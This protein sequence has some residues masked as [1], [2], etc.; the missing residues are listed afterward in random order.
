MTRSSIEVFRVVG[1]PARTDETGFN[2]LG[3]GCGL[4]CGRY[5]VG[6]NQQ[7]YPEG[8]RMQETHVSV[9]GCIDDIEQGSGATVEI[10]TTHE[11]AP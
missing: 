3:W 8:S 4:P 6:W 2:V 9:Y 11:V 1:D 5:Y 10:I 7:A